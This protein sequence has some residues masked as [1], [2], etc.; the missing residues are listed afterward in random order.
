[1]CE[2]GCGIF[3]SVCQREKD[4][5]TNRRRANCP[6]AGLQWFFSSFIFFL[7]HFLI[8]FAAQ[9]D[10][11]RTLTPP[12]P[13]VSTPSLYSVERS[14]FYVFLLPIWRRQATLFFPRNQLLW[15]SLFFASKKAR[16]RG[17]KEKECENM[18]RPH[19]SL[20]GPQKRRAG[21]L[22]GLPCCCAV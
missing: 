12:S 1:M 15:Q 16:L 3:I 9:K 18:P 13:S 7:Q 11:E 17:A 4:S 20:S 6:L 10:E 8:A 21:E 14:T 22:L 5:F 19:V 2:C